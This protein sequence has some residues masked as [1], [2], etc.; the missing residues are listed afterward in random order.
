MPAGRGS[1]TSLVW[2]LMPWAYWP[3]DAFG[4]IGT[5]ATPRTLVGRD[6]VS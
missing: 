3:D 1:F 2:R 5:G 6:G 4:K